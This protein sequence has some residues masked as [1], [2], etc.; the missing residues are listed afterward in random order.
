MPSQF[1]LQTRVVAEVAGLADGAGVP[2]P[3]VAVFSQW[4]K[5]LSY[6]ADLLAGTRAAYTP[7]RQ[8][9][10]D[11]WTEAVHSCEPDI[12][13]DDCYALAKQARAAD[14][15]I[16]QWLDKPSADSGGEH[17]RRFLRWRKT[18]H[19]LLQQK[20]WFTTQACFNHFRMQ[21]QT[22]VM[23]RSMLPESIELA[24]FAEITRLE[25]D[26]LDTLTQ[27]GIQLR[28]PSRPVYRS[29]QV[30]VRH[31]SSLEHEISS[32][33]CWALAEIKAGRSRIAIIIN[34]LD[35]LQDRVIRVFE[36]TFHPDR[37]LGLDD[38][39]DGRFHLSRT[40][41]LASHPLVQQAL[42]LLR[43]SIN[44]PRKPLEFALISRFLL[45]N[46]WS[47][48]E[49][50]G[51]ARAN[52]ELCLRQ[53]G[54]Y[55][56]SLAALA[57]LATR[58]QPQASTPLLIRLCSTLEPAGTSKPPV[59]QILDWLAHWGWPGDQYL[60]QT[61][62]N[63][64]QQLLGGL[65]SLS[66]Q[67]VNDVTEHLQQLQRWCED[68]TVNLHGGA[69]SPLQ[70]MSPAEA[71][72]QRF[73]SAWAANLSDNNW[74]GKTI[75]NAF[76]PA[77]LLRLIPRASDSGMLAY[78]EKLMQGI[79]N[80]SDSVIFS[81]ANRFGDMPQGVSP[82]LSELV[83]SESYTKPMIVPA[84]E[85][86]EVMLSLLS[87]PLAVTIAD[88]GHHPWLQAQ[89]AATGLKLPREETRPLN[90]VVGRFNYQSACPLAAYLVFRLNARMEKPPAPFADA[91][92]RGRLMHA[93]L[94]R[95]YRPFIGTVESPDPSDVAAAV[96]AALRD[97]YAD[98]RLMP[99]SFEAEKIRLQRLLS[100]WLNLHELKPGGHPIE[101]EWQCRLSFA[102]LDFNVRIDRLDR[103]GKDAVFL[104][105][106]KSGYINNPNWAGER[107]GDTQLPLYA[108][109]LEEEGMVHPAG[110]ALLQ[111]KQG[112]FKA[113]G[114]TGV[115][116]S[117]CKGVQLTGSGK[118]SLA[119]TFPD[120][121]AILDFWRAELG[122]LADEI[123][124]GDCRHQLYNEK[125]LQ[126]S[127]LDILL[128][129]SELHHWSLLNSV[130]PATA[131]SQTESEGI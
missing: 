29:G 77:S 113:F 99:A 73:D 74:P 126:Y 97:E 109:A 90:S 10:R 15:L 71:V 128:R 53:K 44:G 41:A 26:L 18:A 35:G 67:S 23:T 75:G 9:L 61:S 127:D 104:L 91:A 89:L 50:E 12:R 52:L 1:A 81:G 94:E 6:R 39:N 125:A 123:Q 46:N 57:K 110:V 66:I 32:M 115:E 54:W 60:D 84:P 129:N 33:A 31:F 64:T 95:L 106:Y 76:I 21:L 36:D 27:T 92:F 114:I 37:V 80:C 45:A 118:G 11:L 3:A 96:A 56:V 117:V 68:T 17:W 51:I 65:E 87:A 25:Q 63:A 7:T 8:Q 70:I 121:R 59:Q 69:F 101:L 93:A 5:D 48:A 58:Q 24:G 72:G 122:K 100:A 111:L 120:W 78:T 105:D 30:S 82:L 42:D 83:L 38:F 13:R 62:I 19:Q 88:Y 130:V 102:G 119:G 86:P 79:V 43:V 108:V 112:D 116:E 55:R 103:V 34:N 98:T 20:N 47:G 4:V 14:R 22:G 2:A 124:R 40:P 107:L 85:R 16:S 131:C 28:Q 49:L